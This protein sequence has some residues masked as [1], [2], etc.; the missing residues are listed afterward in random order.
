MNINQSQT[1]SLLDI[2]KSVD[3]KSLMLPEF[4]RDFRWEV[5]KTYDLIDSLIREIFIGTVIYGKPSFG[6]TL[7]EL[8]TRPRKG[9]GSNAKL[10]TQDYTE[11]QIKTLAQ[12]Q[13]LRIVLDGQQRTTSIYRACKGLDSVYI[14][15]KEGIDPITMPSDLEAIVDDIGGTDSKT[16]VSIKLSDA[17][18]AEEKSWI[19]HQIDEQ[20]N[21]SAYAQTL[22]GDA[23]KLQTARHIYHQAMHK[24]RV[25]LNKQSLVAYYLL[26]MSLDKF[27]LFFERSNSR[28]VALNFTDILAAK[29]YHGFNLRKKIELFESQNKDIRLNREIVVR[30]MAYIVAVESGK[31]I[32]I[33]KG[34][35][36]TNL[37]A[38]DFQ[39]HWDTVCKLYVDSLTYLANQHYILS[40]DWMPSENMVIPIMVFLR[41]IKSFGQMTQTQKEF[42]QFWYWS[43][44]FS[45]RYST[46][47]N[48]TITVD[49]VILRQVAR[50]ER[51]T[52]LGYF[53]KLRSLVTEPA[54][55]LNY[56]RKASSVYRGVAQLWSTLHPRDCSTGKT[57]K[58]WI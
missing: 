51:I 50:G 45:N 26:D 33:D 46:S 9:A 11:A 55:L 6:M 35:I 42:L 57:T 56:N 34:A 58:N 1:E 10:M 43:S 12:T 32:K 25:L 18:E 23:Q 13:S 8:D 47:S 36:L 44:V 24:V 15:I 39:Q 4:Q 21:K 30:A 22:Q 5:E 20:F 3:K 17:C 53:N 48:E 49:C 38:A 31:P 29:L 40:Q 16:N 27:C 7:R 28:G 2:I 37:D 14:N 19:S 52:T 41:E 54:D